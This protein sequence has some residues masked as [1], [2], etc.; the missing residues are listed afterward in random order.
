MRKSWRPIYVPWWPGKIM[1]PIGMAF[2]TLRYFMKFLNNMMR[3]DV[4]K[5]PL[6]GG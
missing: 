1:M 4:E 2:F 5:N 6:V 3:Q